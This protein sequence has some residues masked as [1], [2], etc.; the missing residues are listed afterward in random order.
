MLARIGGFVLFALG[1]V[2]LVVLSVQG[3]G[4][5]LRNTKDL[6]TFAQYLMT[7]SQFMYSALGPCVVVSRFI[8][9]GWFRAAWQAWA[10]FFTAAVASI[11]WAW[12][13]P[14]ISTT[15]GFAGVGVACATGTCFLLTRGTHGMES[16]RGSD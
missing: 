4:N 16:R 8:G 2:L 15:L 11:P 3:F 9:P 12:I 13:E 1:C 7:G 10:L 6:E 5:A 14:S